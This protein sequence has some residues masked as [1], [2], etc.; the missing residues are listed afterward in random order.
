MHTDDMEMPPKKNKTGAVK[1]TPKE[2][3]ILKLWIDQGAK[4]SVQQA[5]QV[6]WQPQAPGVHPIYAAAITEDGR[7]VAC[8]RSN[9]VYLYDLTTRQLVNQIEDSPANFDGAHRAMVQALAFS[10]DGLRLASGS[11]REVKI[12]KREQGEAMARKGDSALGL[13]LATLTPDGKQIVGGDSKGALLILDATTGKVTK[14]IAGAAPSGIELL[15]IS[16]DGSKVAIFAKG[17]Q[18]SV[19]NLREGKQL[20]RQNTPDLALETQSQD[21]S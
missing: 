15:S 18:L 11:F 7:Y 10:P 4:S 20:H 3:G 5:R 17:W 12:W 1:L 6:V 14:K 9:K 21:G 19:W 16:P 8:G 13:R 2:I